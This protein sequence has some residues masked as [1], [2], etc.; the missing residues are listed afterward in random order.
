MASLVKFL[1]ISILRDV[2]IFNK[3]KFHDK[4]NY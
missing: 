1:H 2:N 3:Y 4:F